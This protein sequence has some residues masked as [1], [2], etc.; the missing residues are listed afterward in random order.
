MY[1]SLTQDDVVTE[2]Q[3]HLEGLPPDAPVAASHH[4]GLAAAVLAQ[5]V[6]CRSCWGS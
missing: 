2:G 3:H 6:A 1:L 5:H 4:E